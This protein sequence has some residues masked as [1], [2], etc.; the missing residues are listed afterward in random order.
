VQR[1]KLQEQSEMKIHTQTPT[2]A[3]AAAAMNNDS[4]K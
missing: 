3:A 2:S 1:E 4:C